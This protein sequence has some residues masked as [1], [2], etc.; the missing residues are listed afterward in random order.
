MHR[1]TPG[2]FLNLQDVHA[3]FWI[4]AGT[5]LAAS[6][7]VEITPHVAILDF[8]QE[9]PSLFVGMSWSRSKNGWSNRRQKWYNS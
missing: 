1:A 8:V 9:Y 7:D 2:I 3:H 4:A 5:L 6:G